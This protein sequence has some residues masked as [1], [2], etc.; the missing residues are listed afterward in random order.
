MQ[1][2]SSVAMRRRVRY[3]AMMY[4]PSKHFFQVSTKSFNSIDSTLQMLYDYILRTNIRRLHVLKKK[5]FLCEHYIYILI[6]R[7]LNVFR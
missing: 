3:V 6:I 4:T 5:A 1:L 7:L 2:K